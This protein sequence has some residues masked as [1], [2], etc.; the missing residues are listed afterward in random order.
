MSSLSVEPQCLHGVILWSKLVSSAADEIC[1][2]LVTPRWK[3]AAVDQ[4]VFLAPET[5]TCTA[6]PCVIQGFGQIIRPNIRMFTPSLP[7][8]SIQKPTLSLG[9]RTQ[10]RLE[11]VLDDNGEKS[12]AAVTERALKARLISVSPPNA[13]E[14]TVDSIRTLSLGWA[15]VGFGGLIRAGL[16][17]TDTVNPPR[18]L[19][20]AVFDRFELGHQGAGNFSFVFNTGTVSAGSR[21]YLLLQAVYSGGYTLLL[22]PTPGSDAII[23]RN[24]SQSVVV[25]QFDGSFTVASTAIGGDNQPIVAVEFQGLTL[26]VYATV[27]PLVPSHLVVCCDTSLASKTSKLYGHVDFPSS[28]ILEDPWVHFVHH[29]HPATL[30]KVSDSSMRVTHDPF[31]LRYSSA[32]SM[33]FV[34]DTAPSSGSTVIEIQYTH[35]V[36]KNF[37]VGHV[38]ITLVDADRLDVTIVSVV[39][40]RIH[41][42]PFLFES[43][44][45][46]GTFHLIPLETTVEA[47]NLSAVSSDVH[48]STFYDG[49]LHGLGV[50]SATVTFYSRGLERGVDVQVSDSSVILQSVSAPV[51]YVMYA[52][53]DVTL[54]PIQMNGTLSNGRGVVN[55]SHL[56]TPAID[57]TPYVVLYGSG[58]KQMVVHGNVH[59]DPLPSLKLFVP[60]CP[61]PPD[62]PPMFTVSS[63]LHGHLITP[64]EVHADV[65]IIFTSLDVFVVTLVARPPVFAFYVQLQ[66]DSDALSICRYIAA[67]NSMPLFSDCAVNLPAQGGIVL[68]GVRYTPFPSLRT[69]LVEVV[70]AGVNSIWGYVEVFDGV[71]STRFSI[72]AGEFWKETAIVSA[73]NHSVSR[74]MPSLPLVDTSVLSRHFRDLFSVPRSQT[75]RY[76]FFQ[77]MLLVGRQRYVDTRIY[78]NEFE[79]S[80]MFFVTDRFLQPDPNS[81]TIRVLF[82]TNQLPMSLP[83]STMDQDGQGMWVPAV[84]ALDGWYTVEFRQKIPQMRLT[85]SFTVSTAAFPYPWM[86]DV[87]DTVDIG[88]ALP[89]CPRS[90]TQTATFLASYR[91]TIPIPLDQLSDGTLLWIQNLVDRV[92]CSVQV[93]SRRVMTTPSGKNQ[94]I[95]SV[96]LESLARVHQTNM[97]LMGGWLVDEIQRRISTLT[98][99]QDAS[100]ENLS[101]SLLVTVERGAIDYIND[102][103]DPPTP[104][105]QGFFFSQNGTYMALP[106]HAVPGLDCY[107]MVCIDGYTLM[108][109]THHCIPTPVPT[110]IIWICV[111]VILTVIFCVGGIVCCIH[112]ASWKNPRDIADVVFDPSFDP[113]LPSAPDAVVRDDNTFSDIPFKESDEMER[114]YADC[115]LYPFPSDVKQ[116]KGGFQ[117]VDLPPRLC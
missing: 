110:D 61:M 83:G 31:V 33:W 98:Q 39:L 94:W 56:A 41:C 108:P 19:R 114:Y 42:S 52:V 81:T 104:C 14:I 111:L 65:E 35:P 96:A 48:V 50:G 58:V 101:S 7:R 66:T 77:L 37:V 72:Q 116:A 3:D 26:T 49:F 47:G 80:V 53:K 82:H 78:S 112:L 103:R 40:Q 117:P 22:D 69:D 4:L 105:P 68:A 27:I 89:A 9:M 99:M 57:P 59:V 64:P 38:H 62:S 90:A 102:T 23:V 63:F 17:T 21:G 8:I 84:H 12:L 34:V 20:G 100:N 11:C 67:H 85:V 91:I 92:A 6:Y 51:D 55:I 60:A 93:P 86:W 75:L 18:T 32:L 87:A 106:Q 95:L 43:V 36:T 54:F 113:S 115:G 10:W 73:G 30:I 5:Y 1:K 24:A 74:L 13:L 107:D 25:S 28:F 76:A 45:V 88:L 79:L 46:H 15:T 97:V 16:N 2:V 109:D 71:T 70:G 29:G 44:P